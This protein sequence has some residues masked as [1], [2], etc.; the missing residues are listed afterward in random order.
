MG[1][2]N[3]GFNKDSCFRDIF[4]NN[5][6]YLREKYL[7]RLYKGNNILKERENNSY[8][9]DKK[10]IKRHLKVISPLI[11]FE[12]YEFNIIEEEEYFDVTIELEADRLYHKYVLTWLRYLYEFPFNM[13]IKDAKRMRKEKEFRFESLSNLFVVISNCYSDIFDREI[14]L[15]SWG[16]F[17]LLKNKQIY[18]KLKYLIAINDRRLNNIYENKKGQNLVKGD[19]YDIK[20]WDSEDEYKK[21]LVIYKESYKKCKK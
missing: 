7:I 5:N 15:I 6:T 20:F 12:K 1:T 17:N 3:K 14:H 8:F 2:V 4:K 10:E 16:S 11:V 18:E 13:I 21:R 19:L 9:S